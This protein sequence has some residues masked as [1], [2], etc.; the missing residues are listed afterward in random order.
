VGNNIYIYI[1]MYI[2]AVPA[3][4]C[5]SAQVGDGSDGHLQ[6]DGRLELDAS[7]HHQ[8]RSVTVKSGCILTSKPW[9]GYVYSKSRRPTVVMTLFLNVP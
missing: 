3:L 2:C 9:D 8:F 7:K 4:P 5:N 6:V 1:Y